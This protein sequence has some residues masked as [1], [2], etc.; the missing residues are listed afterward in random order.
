MICY[1]L[2]VVGVFVSYQSGWKSD[3]SGRGLHPVGR[4]DAQ[5]FQRLAEDFLHGAD[6][7]QADFGQRGIIRQDAALAVKRVEIRRQIQHIVHDKVRRPVPGG[8][9]R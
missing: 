9:C 6:Q 5:Q 8:L 4:G 7:H 3:G 1:C 2:V